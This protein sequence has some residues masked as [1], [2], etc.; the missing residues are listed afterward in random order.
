M[1]SKLDI[2]NSRLLDLYEIASEEGIT[3]NDDS[4]SDIEVFLRSH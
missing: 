3:I 2:F 4:V 1:T